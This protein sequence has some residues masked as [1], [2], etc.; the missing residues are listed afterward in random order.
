MIRF[1][2]AMA[3]IVL[4]GISTGH[5]QKIYQA[6]DIQ[7]ASITIFA[8]DEPDQADLWVCFVWEE[9]EITRTGLWM[10]M[11]FPHEA[12]VIIFFV[13]EEKGADLKIWLVDTAEESKWLN[14]SKKHLLKLKE[15]KE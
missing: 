15:P 11:R 8:V 2:S 7:N 12:D 3:L 4:L 13:D 5:A 9:T 14:E 6:D 10:D 1:L